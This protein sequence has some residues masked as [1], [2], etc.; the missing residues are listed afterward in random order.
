MEH[1]TS[2]NDLRKGRARLMAKKRKHYREGKYVC[3]HPFGCDEWLEE[4]WIRH[5]DSCNGW[6]WDK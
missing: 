1:P 4:D 2:I 5:I 6:K 3:G